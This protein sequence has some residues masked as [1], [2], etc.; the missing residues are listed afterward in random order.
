MKQL[1]NLAV[2]CAQRTNVLLQILSG[3][4]TVFVGSGPGRKSITVNWDDD[5]RISEVIQKLNF[6]ELSEED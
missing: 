2:I 3:K 5:D 1:G 6:G 4:A